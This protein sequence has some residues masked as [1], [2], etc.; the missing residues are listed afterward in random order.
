MTVPAS[1][2]PFAAPAAH[3]DR[4]MGRFTATLAPALADFAGVGPGM[5]VLDVGCGPGGLTGELVM[6]VGAPRVAAI[7]PA[8]QFVAACRARYPGVDVREGRAE[9][10][11]WPGDSFDAAAACL[12]IG[13]MTDPNAGLR[14]MTRVVRPGGTVAACM[15]DVAGDGMTM[16]QTFWNAARTVDPEAPGE[17]RLAGGAEGD[18]A[19]RMTAAGLAEVTAGSLMAQARYADFDDFWE[20]FTYAVGPAGQYLRAQSADR[21]DRIRDACRAALPA[22]SFTLTARAWC[23]RGT[24]PAAV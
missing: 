12:V 20:P 7:D 14:E 21:Q 17:R 6:R 22:S 15:W 4:Y 11:P 24:V 8:A 23:A 10:L 2:A 1:S 18:I 19:R 3:Y 13:F 16:L 9:E 5:R